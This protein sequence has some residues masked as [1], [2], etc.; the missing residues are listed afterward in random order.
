[1]LT[2]PS[3]LHCANVLFMASMFASVQVFN[4]GFARSIAG[5]GQ[6][7]DGVEKY[8]SDSVINPP[9]IPCPSTKSAHRPAKPYVMQVPYIFDLRS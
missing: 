9:S 1:M 4:W 8:L 3:A 5:E 2:L 7:G 6:R